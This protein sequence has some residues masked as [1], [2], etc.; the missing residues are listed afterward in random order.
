MATATSLHK[1][2]CG[3]IRACELTNL[4]PDICR[5]SSQAFDKARLLCP[6]MQMGCWLGQNL[7]M[8]SKSQRGDCNA[9]G[10]GAEPLKCLAQ[11]EAW[12]RLLPALN[13]TG[14]CSNSLR[15]VIEYINIPAQ[16]TIEGLVP[17]SYKMCSPDSTC[18]GAFTCKLLRA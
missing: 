16:P 12:H 18:H 3:V 5:M 14:R 8:Y 2:C 13:F 15:L 4:V 6:L 11:R 10:A 1:L 9:S 7:A 17:R